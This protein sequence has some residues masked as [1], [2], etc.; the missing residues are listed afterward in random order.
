MNIVATM[1]AGF[2]PANS[3]VHDM[4]TGGGRIIG[5]ACHFIDLC[6][7]FTG[8]HV[9]AVVMNA[10][11]SPSSNSDNASILLKYADGSNATVNYFANGS[12]SYAKERIEIYSQ[13]RTAVIDNW[14]VSKGYGFKGFKS[15]KTAL[16]K[17]HKNQFQLLI[18]R[19]K[20]GGAE[21][22]SFDSLVNTTRASI[23]ALKS[24]KEL[25]WVNV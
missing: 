18:D 16:D 9:V 12:K 7:Y 13:E 17:G 14:C 15:L 24:L 2:I 21:L 10:L 6:S 20:N 8:S 3:W 25:S 19:T 5:E 22:I 23:A 11:G 1:N 4:Q